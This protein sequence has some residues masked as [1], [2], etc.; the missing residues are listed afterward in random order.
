MVWRATPE[1]A[2]HTDGASRKAAIAK[3]MG[4]KDP[5]KAK[6]RFQKRMDEGRTGIS[7]NVAIVIR[8]QEG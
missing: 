3:R 5:A 7:P 6:E 2:K 4:I 8:E 1:E